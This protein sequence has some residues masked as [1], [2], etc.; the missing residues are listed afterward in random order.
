LE[1]LIRVALDNGALGAKLSGA[2]LGGNMIALVKE[3]I[4]DNVLNGINQAGA[5]RAILT[6]LE[7]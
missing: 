2:G 5:S 1:N 4:A 3:D 7:Q 6:V